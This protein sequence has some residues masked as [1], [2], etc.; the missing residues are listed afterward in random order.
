MRK[1]IIE[2]AEYCLNCKTKPCSEKGCP[3]NNNIP[4]VI[5]LVKEGKNK[6]AYEELT[7]TT[8]LP[9]ICGRICPHFKQCMGSCTRGIKGSPVQI[10]EIEAYIG[11]EAIKNGY[12][13][14]KN[15]NQD[16]KNKK[17]AIVGGGPAGLSA[18][19]FLAKRGAECTIYEKYAKLGGILS[20]GIPE[21]RLPKDIVEKSINK[22]LELGINV[23]YSK[24]LGKN[25]TL[26]ELEERYDNIILAFGA[27]TSSKMNIE[28]EDLQGVYGGNELLEYSNHPN[29]TEKTVIINGGGNVAIDVARTVKKMGAKKV[30]VV[31]RRARKQMPAEEKE[32]EEAIKEGIEFWFQNNIIKIIGENGKVKKVELIKTKLIQKEGDSRLSPVNIEKSNFFVDADYVIMALG[33]HPEEFIKKL[34]LELNEK[35]QIKVDKNGKTSNPIIYA[36]GDIAGNIG[37]IAWAARSGRD[38]IQYMLN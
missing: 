31:Y 23:K 5:Q 16:L 3:L 14:L 33:A 22:I 4:K 36:I 26:K 1:E 27:N 29:Y 15:I 21:F 7:K 37:T 30:I 6:E 25:I 2:K 35:G 8:V 11:D 20:H 9:S 18:A 24:E 28:G 19:A 13:I 32:V 10:G 34:D 17:V 38:V 12:K